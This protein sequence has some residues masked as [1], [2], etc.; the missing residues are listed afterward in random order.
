MSAEAK[1][2][3]MKP[4]PTGLWVGL[5]GLA[6]AGLVFVVYAGCSHRPAP[7]TAA[8]NTSRA[9]RAS[10]VELFPGDLRRLQPHLGLKATACVRLEFE[11]PARRLHLDAELWQEGKPVRRPGGMSGYTPTNWPVDVSISLAPAAGPAG[12]AQY[13]VTMAAVDRSTLVSW[14]SN[15]PAPP[16]GLYTHFRELH[17]PIEIGPGPPVPVWACL[18]Y[19]TPNPFPEGWPSKRSFDEAARAAEWAIV[20]K[21][22]WTEPTD[23]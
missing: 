7:P 9:L 5:A 18:A 13:R 23:P 10:N 19:K 16:E 11:P 20:L 22:G 21:V 4:F 17:E 1:P 15:R 6:V 12:S 2:V 14:E 8:A 3:A